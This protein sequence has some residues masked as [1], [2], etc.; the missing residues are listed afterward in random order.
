[1]GD[2]DDPP[3]PPHGVL[4]DHARRRAAGRGDAD[5]AVGGDDVPAVRRLRNRGEAHGQPIPDRVSRRRQGVGAGVARDAGG[6]AHEEHRRERRPVVVLHVVGGPLGEHDAGA[7]VVRV[8]DG[9]LPGGR[10]GR[11]VGVAHRDEDRAEARGGGDVRVGRHAAGDERGR[12]AGRVERVL[13]GRVDRRRAVGE[14]QHRGVAGRARSVDALQPGAAHVA[15]VA[16]A[17]RVGVGVG[18]APVRQLVAVAV[19]VAGT[20]RARAGRRRAGARGHVVVRARDAAGA[21]VVGVDDR[22][23]LAAV[24]LLVAVAV[25]VPR[26]ARAVAGVVAAGDARHVV[27]R[28]GEATAA[29]VGRVGRGERLAAVRPLVAVAVRSPARARARAHADGARRHWHVV[30]RAIEATASA[31]RR[32]AVDVLLAAVRLLV[33]VAVRVAGRARAVADAGRARAGRH[34]AVRADDAAP[35]AV[36]RVRRRVHL[37]AVRLLVVVAVEERAD[38]R[39]AAHA[40]RARHRRD[41]VRGAHLA[42]AA[43]VRRVGGDVLLAAVRLLVAVAVREAGRASPV[44]HAAGAGDG[45]H[46]VGRADLVARPAVRG[47]GPGVDL[48]AVRLL[49]AVA[50]REAGRA[51]AVADAARARARRHAGARADD[52]A[53]AAVVGIARAGGLAAV[54]L[55]VGVAV[56]VAGGA[57]AVAHATGA[58]DR[59]HVVARAG[60]AAA[61]ARGD[62]AEEVRLAAARLLVAV[63][64]GEARV[65]GAV[66]RAG[67]ARR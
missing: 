62:S 20:A 23:G 66:A 15:A 35:A 41:V 67:G 16:A 63:A 22:I 17:V 46:V 19:R 36:V 29:T 33:R 65:A 40:A 44:A 53:A 56:A 6:P 64:V 27:R 21:A 7:R 50:V 5:T 28:A 14:E 1:M 24:E 3:L 18:L 8:H 58:G 32:A 43:A 9:G 13:Q 38:A 26:R 52:A 61:T 45:R 11:P 42:A 10:H 59:R 4:H 34:V 57:R 12:D 25:V 51:D 54:R 30:V 31:V 47:V 60:D 55:L 39:A 48:A 37:A 49:V 2:L